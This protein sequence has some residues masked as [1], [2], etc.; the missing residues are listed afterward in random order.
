MACAGIASRWNR[1][2]GSQPLAEFNRV[3]SINKSKPTEI[4]GESRW[5]SIILPTYNGAKTL[6]KAIDSILCQSHGAFELIVVD[7]YSSDR[8]ADI[9][10]DAVRRDRRIRAIYHKK[11]IGLAG[12]LNEGLREAKYEFVARMDQDDEAL[13]E[14]LQ[15]QV[16]FM[17]QHTEL[18]VVGTFVYLMG[19]NKSYD[20]LLTAPTDHAA[21][22]NKLPVENCIFHP[23][24]MMRRSVILGCGGYRE[25]FANAEDYDLWLRVSRVGKLANIPEGLLRYSFTPS[26]MTLRRKWQQLAFVYKAQI[27]FE[28]PNLQANEIEE[29]SSVRLRSTDRR[30]FFRAVLSGT[31]KEMVEV[32]MYADAIRCCWQLKKEVGF[33]W[34]IRQLATT[35]STK[36]T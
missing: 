7:D 17:L 30:Q 15:R 2:T 3:Q 6:S 8:S 9:I 14:R 5:V 29:L 4:A 19:R 18:C 11:N 22:A 24:V 21:I 33:A 32:S 1:E 36:A 10:R 27:S 25:N 16:A 13:P 20:K 12:T 28:N 26:G 35:L 31:I 34:S 23:S